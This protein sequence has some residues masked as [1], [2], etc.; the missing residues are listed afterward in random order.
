VVYDYVRSLVSMRKEHPAFRMTSAAQITAN[1][2]FL[3]NLPPG[4]IAYTING[5]AVKDSW[6]KILV[7]FNGTAGKLS[8]DVPAGKW[9]SFFET[10]GMTKG[11]AAMSKTQTDGYSAAIYFIK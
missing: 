11:K 10:P 5:A 3:D 8:I 1:I 2:K 7:I 4:V 9:T 6:K